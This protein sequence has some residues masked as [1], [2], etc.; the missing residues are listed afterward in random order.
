MYSMNRLKLIIPILTSYDLWYDPPSGSHTGRTRQPGAGP[1]W[2]I[3]ETT[4]RY[5][6]CSG[7]HVDALSQ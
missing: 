7:V 1:T 6:T 4:S 2:L 5:V 3:E